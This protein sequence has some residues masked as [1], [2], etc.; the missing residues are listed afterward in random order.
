MNSFKYTPLLG[1]IVVFF[2]TYYV[3]SLFVGGDQTHYRFIYDELPNYGFFDGY[4]F[5]ISRIYTVEFGHYVISWLASHIF[6]KDLFNAFS[7]AL[8]AFFSVNLFLKWGAKPFIAFLLVVFG[9]YHL[10]VYVSAE[11]LKY[12]FLFFTVALLYINYSKIKYLFS[13]LALVTH[14]QFLILVIVI[15]SWGV[16]RDFF[17]TTETL[18]VSR[19]TL[20]SAVLVF[21]ISVIL[22]YIFYGHLVHKLNSYHQSFTFDEYSRILLFFLLSFFYAKNRLQVVLFFSILIL[23][24]ALVGGMRVNLFGYFIF[25]YYALRVNGGLNFGVVLTTVYYAVG[26]VGYIDLV[27]N[28]GVNRAV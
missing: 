1:S 23:T 7:N 22:L 9:Y 27:I 16:V 19:K 24:V 2:Y 8:L 6:A 18:R 12:A 15:S 17:Y 3:G 10:A 21:I 28:N 13:V 14:M 11:R 26:W 4:L 20:L 5:Y 25:L